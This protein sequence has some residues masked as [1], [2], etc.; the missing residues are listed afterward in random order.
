MHGTRTER[1]VGVHPLVARRAATRA[2]SASP[3]RCGAPCCR[4]APSMPRSAARSSSGAEVAP[5]STAGALREAWLDRRPDPEL[6]DAWTLMIQAMAEQLPAAYLAR[7]R[8][9][10]LDRARAVAATTGGVLGMDSKVSASEAKMLA[11]L[12]AAFA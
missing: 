1:K 2:E 10:L 5:D 12:E 7:L 8:A 3:T 4:M 11:R 6:L 9:G